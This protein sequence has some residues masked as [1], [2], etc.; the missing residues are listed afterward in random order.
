MRPALRWSAQA[1]GARPRL[2]L[3]LFMTASPSSTTVSLNQLAKASGN[4]YAQWRVHVEVMIP[5]IGG[6]QFTTI[7]QQI[8]QCHCKLPKP[9]ISMVS[10]PIH[11]AS[12]LFLLFF[13]ALQYQV[14]KGKN[15]I[16][17][18]NNSF[19]RAQVF[20]CRCALITSEAIYMIRIL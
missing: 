15:S 2:R 7:P 12:L 5:H 6:L 10:P 1:V 11:L 13:P 8:C 9:L 20:L 3:Q 14:E 4:K 16:S 19:T 17:Y 18:P